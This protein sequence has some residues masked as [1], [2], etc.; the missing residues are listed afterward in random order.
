MLGWCYWVVQGYCLARSLRG[1]PGVNV[2]IPDTTGSSPL[3]YL[4]ESQELELLQQLLAVPGVNLQARNARGITPIEQARRDGKL[5]VLNLLHTAE[6]GEAPP[7][8]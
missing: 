5:G 2:N 8:M 1:I 4:V 3:H 7:V 6:Y